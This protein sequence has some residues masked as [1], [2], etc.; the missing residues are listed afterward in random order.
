AASKEITAS[1]RL[2]AAAATS[3][4]LPKRMSASRKCFEKAR[5]KSYYKRP[6]RRS[7]IPSTPGGRHGPAE[8]DWLDRPRAQGAR[9]IQEL[10]SQGQRDRPRGGRDHRRRVRQDHRFPGQAHPH[11]AR[12]TAPSGRA[13]LPRLED[14][15]RRQGSPLRALPRRDRELHHHRARALSLHRE[16]S[17]LDD[18]S[19]AA[20]AA[21]PVEGGAAARRDPRPAEG[22]EGLKA[23][24][25]NYSTFTP[26]AR[27]SFPHFS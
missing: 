8:I 18:E 26:I 27:T 1:A 10:R 13:G 14:R 15:G 25:G 4:C 9:G 19:K 23:P 20:R 16:V 6:R 2:K 17:R 11:A 12:W 24:R 22:A 3:E 21:R 5:V 7:P